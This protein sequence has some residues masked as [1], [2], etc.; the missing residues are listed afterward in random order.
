MANFRPSQFGPASAAHFHVLVAAQKTTDG[1]AYE[2]ECCRVKRVSRIYVGRKKY[3]PSRVLDLNGVSRSQ[4][5]DQ[6]YQ[7]KLA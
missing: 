5:G 2:K 7:E 3:Q 6:R 4:V 1:M